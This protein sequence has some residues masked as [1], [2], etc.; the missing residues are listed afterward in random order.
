MIL[1]SAKAL[2]SPAREGFITLMQPDGTSFK[3][4][5]QGDEFLRIKTTADGHAIIQ[6]QNGWWCY[7]LYS[8][9]GTKRS[10]GWRIGQES[11]ADIKTSSTLIPYHVLKTNALNKRSTICNEA[12]GAAIKRFIKAQHATKASTATKHGIIILAQFQDIKFLN[13]REDFDALLN[14]TGYSKNGA[15]GSAKDYFDYQFD[16]LV[17][18]RFDVSNI[19]TLAGKR[20]YYG[21]NNTAGDDSRPAELIAEACTL[22]EQNGTDF[23]LYDDDGDGFVDNVFVFFAGE[24]EAEGG[25][26]NC[27]WSHSWYIY[28]GAG[29]TL[30]L[31]GKLIDRYACTSE[32][33][34]VYS[35]DG[36]LEETRMSGIGTFCHE[37]SHTFGLPDL[38]DTDYDGEGGWAA[39]VWRSTSLMDSGNQNNDG[40]TPPNFN[41]IEREI[42]GIAKPS[43]INKDG[44]YTLRPIPIHND[45][46]K[47]ETDTEG[48]YYLFEYRNENDTWDS[49]IG[50]SGMLVYHI[51]KSESMMKRWTL[52]NTVNSDAS[53]QCADL[54]EA[55]SR[56]D[57]Y[58]STQDYLTR[59]K[60]IRSI[61][62]P[63]DKVNSIPATG[64]PGLNFWSSAKG[65]YSITDIKHHPDMEKVTFSVIGGSEE[66]TP[67]NVTQDIDYEVFT[68][69]AIIRFK[70]SREYDGKAV[71]SYGKASQEDT[72]ITMVTPYESGKYSIEVKDLESASTYTFRIHFE[73]NGV[74]GEET[75][76][77]FMTKKQPV[78][79]W[80]YIYVSNRF[81]NSNGTFL[82]DARIPLKTYNTREAAN[83]RWTF[84]GEEIQTE[85]DHYYTLE[86]S[87]E[88]Q[89]HITWEDGSTDI[90]SKFIKLSP[91]TAQ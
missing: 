36:R 40:N 22:A 33:T 30:S 55:D 32:M 42:L 68:D 45:C 18:F 75:S 91:M 79:S 13:T 39:G 35:E 50:G 16:G 43:V 10:S 84:N 31:N 71:I 48:E 11:P 52:H 20:E 44:I 4:L 88:L 67:P 17:D 65:T 7:A 41:A 80:P 51:D 29:I 28:Q 5:L 82:F 25:D 69:G 15:T 49:H 6:E 78:V 87:G 57:S 24:D 83:I 81:R 9:D 64:K 90:L 1:S 3:A 62:F 27:I 61:F 12:D 74:K 77:S 66:T 19:V 54:I 23:S 86:E 58:T 21:G 60:N 73:I 34:R 8:E 72:T 53:H 2:C 38:Y 70:S 47:M 37:Y 63:Y 59:S 14:Q 89:A 85:S 76:L 56:N 26:E 46:L